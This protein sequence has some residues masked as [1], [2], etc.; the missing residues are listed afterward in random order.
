MLRRGGR[1]VAGNAD[2]IAAAIRAA[3]DDPALRSLPLIGS[4]DQVTDS[5]P[6]IEAPARARAAIRALFDDVEAGALEET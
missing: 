2:E 6:V 1:A 4:L 5:T 3:I